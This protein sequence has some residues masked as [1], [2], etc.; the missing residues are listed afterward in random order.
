MIAA[1]TVEVHLRACPGRLRAVPGRGRAAAAPAGAGR[2][3]AAVRGRPRAAP[4]ALRRRRLSLRLRL[5][6]DLLPQQLRLLLLPRRQHR[7]PAL[8]QGARRGRRDLPLA[9]GLGR[10]PA[11]PDARRGSAA[12][13]QRRLLAAHR[14]GGGRAAGHRPADHGLA[15]RGA[16]A[17]ARRA[18]RRRR[19]LLRRLPGDALPRSCSPGCGSARASR[20]APRRA[21]TRTPPAC[22]SRTACSPASA[23]VRPTGRARCSPCE[24]PATSRCAS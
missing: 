3:G 10:Q 11:R 24:R 22:W 20:G 4:A 18:A 15:R 1:E 14:S 19:R 9:G 21:G 12:L 13:R 8:S 17:R 5:L 23:T 7:Q 6:L 16:P 2:G